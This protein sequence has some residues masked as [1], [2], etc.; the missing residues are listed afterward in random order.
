MN[1]RERQ[2][3]AML[4][5]AEKASQPLPVLWRNQVGAVQKKEGD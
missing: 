3:F 5:N 2:Q 1:A 4:W